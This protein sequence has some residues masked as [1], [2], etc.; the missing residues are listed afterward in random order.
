MKLGIRDFSYLKLEI[1]D[2][3]YMK[4]GI[5]EFPYLKLGIRVLKQNQGEFRDW[6]CDAEKT[7]R[8]KGIARNFGSG[9]RD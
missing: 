6:R 2:F 3:P 7:T 9:L 5:R 1:R 4:L 8:F